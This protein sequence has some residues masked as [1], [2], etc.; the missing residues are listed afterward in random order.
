V[1]QFGPVPPERALHFLRQICASLAE[2]HEAG[3]VHRDVKPANMYTCRHGR[4]VDFVKVLDFGLVKAVAG[5]KNTGHSLETAAGLTPGTPSYMAPEMAMGETIDGRADIYA[6][7]CV[8]YWL[9]TGKRVFEAENALQ[10]VA[11]HVRT[12]PVPPSERVSGLSV[13]PALESLVLA[14][15]AKEPEKRPDAHELGKL[16]ADSNSR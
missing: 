3:L 16:L 8:A 6:L 9:L 2:A 14:C 13:P 15:L 10:V 5:E 11:K 7:G 1:E 4:E 12:P